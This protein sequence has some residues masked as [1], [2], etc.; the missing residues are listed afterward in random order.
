MANERMT[1]A[2][3]LEMAIATLV[4]QGF[5]SEVITKLTNI[6]T[7]YEKKSGS[8]KKPTANQLAN[9]KIKDRI[10][11]IL[12]SDSERLFTITDIVKSLDEDYT[13][14]K[15]SALCSALYNDNRITKTVDK[16]KTYYTSK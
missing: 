9:E 15:I 13:N 12:E 4:E 16:R 14:Q 11:E 7:S 5:D 8:A 10:V 3:A 2:K 1:N 6:R